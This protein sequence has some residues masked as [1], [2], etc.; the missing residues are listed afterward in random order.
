MPKLGIVPPQ[1]E[2]AS[3]GS[4]LRHSGGKFELSDS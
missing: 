3:R 4:A 1:L 2:P